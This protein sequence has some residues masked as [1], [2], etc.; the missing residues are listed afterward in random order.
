MP[1]RRPIR[2]RM[3][4]VAAVFTR[5]F[6][7]ADPT[8][9][10]RQ[11]VPRLPPGI[12]VRRLP[13][14]RPENKR[15]WA[16]LL[17]GKTAVIEWRWL[18]EMDRRGVLAADQRRRLVLIDGE[19]ALQIRVDHKSSMSPFD[20]GSDARAGENL[21]APP[22]SFMPREAWKPILGPRPNAANP[23]RPSRT[24][25]Q[26][27]PS[28]ASLNAAYPAPNA[29]RSTR[30]PITSTA[31]APECAKDDYLANGWP[32]ASGPVEG[33]CKNL[34]K[35]RMERSGM[36]WI[37]QMAEAICTTASHLSLRTL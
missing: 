5:A 22:M 35:D 2:K 14:P 36:R 4:T 23:L 28:G 24:S 17:K 7:G 26:R 18:V 8:M 3:A 1:G 20:S 12:V 9:C 11:P 30:S 6:L 27:H 10:H 37:E 32:I 31:T 19:R 15:V 29:K 34:I 16:S 13:P 25:R 33:A 21:E